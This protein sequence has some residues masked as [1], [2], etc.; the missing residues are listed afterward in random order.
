MLAQHWR[1][2]NRTANT[3]LSF[4]KGRLVSLD[5]LRGL[6]VAL[7]ILVNTP[8]GD[9]YYSFL[10]HA[11]W[12]G[13][14]FADIVFPFFIFIL[15]V[16]VPYA[17]SR[18]LE[19]G[20]NRKQLLARVARRT[21]ILFALGLLLNLF[22][23][24][25]L[26][27]LRVMGVLQRIALC[28]F[29]A[30]VLFLFLKPKWRVVLTVA[31]PIVYWLLMALVPVPG[32]GAGV[33]TEDGNLAAYV[34][35]LLLN[36]HLYTSTWDPEG[37]L[38]TLPAVATALMGVLAG[39]YLR[40]ERKPRMKALNLLVFGVVAVCVGFVWNFW[41]PVNKNLWTSS[42]V[43]VTGGIAV[44][45]LAAFF[46]VLDVKGHV[47]W[48]K[49]FS[50]LGC[51]SLFVFVLSEFLNL[52]LIRAGVKSVLF[53]GLFASWAGP[54]HGSFFYALAFLAFCWAVAAILYWKRIFIRI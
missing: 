16:A 1:M 11:T 18:R 15:G 26:P 4:F 54:L 33:L 42:Y 49:P 7:M 41:F 12:N 35:R 44:M 8:G 28:Y 34:D 31:I 30:S 21:I 2:V 19:Q 27:A 47:R 46:Y 40:S 17:F 32:Y 22:S 6:T 5:V 9:E 48:S 14:T 24:F 37:V 50:V 39:M 53:E 25:D 13:L 10:Q 23:T 45:L 52:A 29:F 3:T 36:G 38:S 20:A 51:N 43:A